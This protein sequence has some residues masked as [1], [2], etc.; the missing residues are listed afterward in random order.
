MSD[1]AEGVH[2]RGAVLK[3]R[4]CEF[5]VPK[6]VEIKSCWAL[7]LN[8]HIFR[9]LL[10]LTVRATPKILV[11]FLVQGTHARNFIVR[12]S[13]FFSVIQQQTRPRLKI[14]KKN[15]QLNVRFSYTSNF[16]KYHVVHKKN[17]TFYSVFLAKT[18]GLTLHICRKGVILLLLWM[19][20]IL[21]KAHSYSILCDFAVNN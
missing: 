2:P 19:H 16:C 14:K 7:S 13:H 15:L 12:F 21:P 20:C 4:G 8:K 18:L 5:V 3:G 6:C 1:L 9:W 11:P 10:Y 17:A